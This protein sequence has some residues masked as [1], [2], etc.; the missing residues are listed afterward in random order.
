[1]KKVLTQTQP[2]HAD[3]VHALLLGVVVDFHFELSPI[4]ARFGKLGPTDL[5]SPLILAQDS[6][7]LLGPRTSHVEAL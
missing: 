5:L 6:P 1:M 2:P 7:L 4:F 3:I